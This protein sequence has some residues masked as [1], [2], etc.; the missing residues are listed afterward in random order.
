MLQGN[1]E[2]GQGGRAAASGRVGLAQA[3]WVGWWTGTILIVL[4][5]IDVVSATVGWIGFALALASTGLNVVVGKYW[6]FPRE[7]GRRS[8]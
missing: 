7:G 6:R 3:C 2:G 1:A 4:S 5:W 8:T